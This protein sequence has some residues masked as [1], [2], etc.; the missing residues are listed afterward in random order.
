[1]LKGLLS[2]VPIVN[3]TGAETG[4]VGIESVPVFDPAANTI[5]EGVGTAVVFDEENGIENSA[6]GAALRVTVAKAG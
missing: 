2:V 1:V 5:A 3:V 6:T 4:F